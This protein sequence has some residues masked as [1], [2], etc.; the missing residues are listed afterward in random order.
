V[1][2]RAARLLR[3]GPGGLSEFATVTGELH[4]RHS[5]GGWS[6]ARFKR[7]IEEQVAV[8]LRGETDRL[9]RAHLRRPLSS[10]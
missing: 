4:R 7:G 1:S 10:S 3:G 2:R 8:H 6:Q 5:Q 9:L